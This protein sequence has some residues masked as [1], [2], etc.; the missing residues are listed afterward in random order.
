[1]ISIYIVRNYR[2]RLKL[3]EVTKP[4]NHA[5]EVKVPFKHSQKNEETRLCLYLGAILRNGNPHDSNGVN[6]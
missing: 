3:P 1:M 6:E 4:V 2:I 5:K